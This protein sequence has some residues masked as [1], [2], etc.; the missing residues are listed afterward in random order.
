MAACV[1]ACQLLAGLEPREVQTAD[2]AATATDTVAPI[3][4]VAEAACEK[5]GAA[6]CVDLS[7]DPKNCGFCG[8]ACG[9][10]CTGGLCP[11]LDVYTGFSSGTALAIDAQNLYVSERQG[12]WAV[13]KSDNTP[14]KLVTSF[15]PQGVT[16]AAGRVYVSELYRISSVQPDGGQPQLIFAR[17]AGV[18]VP[19]NGDIAADPPWVFWTTQ[20]GLSS[21]SEDG[22]GLVPI[23]PENLSADAGL[24]LVS[25]AVTSSHVYFIKGG[26]LMR[27]TRDG[28]TLTTIGTSLT[29]GTRLA[30][31]SDAVIW[32]DIATIRRTG[33]DGGGAALLATSSYTSDIAV[34][35]DRIYW[36][37]V[38]TG[39]QTG[40]IM[41]MPLAGGDPAQLAANVRLP[42]RIVV[43]DAYVYW[44]ENVTSANLPSPI[45][46]VAR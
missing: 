5:C 27:A 44:L 10:A 41:T 42:G 39:T 34:Y 28:A 13:R 8:H 1:V 46:K 32:G 14:Q 6:T 7:T 33:F 11:V 2:D 18:N 36:S 38:G 26:V 9:G 40:A 3:D 35:K 23:L 21:A 31:T 4:V 30:L 16:T 12:V 22:G 24:G 43:D 15:V 20:A 29:G 45:R 17:D 19:L 37:Q 25:P